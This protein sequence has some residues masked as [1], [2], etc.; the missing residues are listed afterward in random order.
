MEIQEKLKKAAL[1]FALGFLT[2]LAMTSTCNQNKKSAKPAPPAPVPTTEPAL[3]PSAEPTPAPP[4]KA[5]AITVIKKKTVPTKIAPTPLPTS[6]PMPI[7]DI[8]S[9]SVTISS[10][11][12]GLVLRELK[13]NGP[14]PKEEE[15]KPK[16]LDGLPLKYDFKI[17]NQVGEVKEYSLLAEGEEDPM[18]LAM[19]ELAEGD[20][21]LATEMYKNGK[22]NQAYHLMITVFAAFPENKEP[23]DMKVVL[24][25]SAI[26]YSRTLPRRNVDKKI[27]PLM[28]AYRYGLRTKKL[29]QKQLL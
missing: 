11:V 8:K 27:E 17:K 14:L 5:T 1:P 26:E 12:N 20:F 24:M 22:F 13:G 9:W 19:I 3:E 6:T 21:L 2:A 23:F 28:F 18:E 7:P 10:P 4:A 15:W 16:E 25:E 29:F